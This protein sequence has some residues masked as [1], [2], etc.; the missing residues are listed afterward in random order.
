MLAGLSRHSA[1]SARN[2]HK[3]YKMIDYKE[4]NTPMSSYGILFIL[5]VTQQRKNL[6]SSVRAGSIDSDH[7][8]W[9]SLF[10]NLAQFCVTRK[11]D[12]KNQKSLKTKKFQYCIRVIYISFDFTHQP[13]PNK[14]KICI[15]SFRHKKVIVESLKSE[16]FCFWHSNLI[17]AQRPTNNKI[18]WV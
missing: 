8:D 4:W 16:T 5:Y 12:T 18:R 2:L 7:W 10:A 11:L 1:V 14:I 9:D 6:G 13:W 3:M 17:F 15:L